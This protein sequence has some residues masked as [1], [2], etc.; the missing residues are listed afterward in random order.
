M[1]LSEKA[2]VVERI[3]DFSRRFKFKIVVLRWVVAQKLRYDDKIVAPDKKTRCNGRYTTHSLGNNRRLCLKLMG[4]HPLPA[5]GRLLHA[6]AL[7]V[8]C[9]LH[10]HVR[11][12]MRRRFKEF[13]CG[14]DRLVRITRLEA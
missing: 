7:D 9:L 14:I 11:V 8:R 12:V 13:G 10:S 1:A 6:V 5:T 4:L 3:G 2:N